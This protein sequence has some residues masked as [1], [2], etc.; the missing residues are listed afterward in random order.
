MSVHD[1]NMA[2]SGIGGLDAVFGQ[3]VTYTP[4]GE[5]GQECTARFTPT[6][7]M[8]VALEHGG[9]SDVTSGTLHVAKTAI[10]GTPV[11][12]ATVTIGSNTYDL[13]EDAI[14]LGSMWEFALELVSTDEIA[15]GD[16]HGGT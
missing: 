15:A 13:S 12:G 9:V 5:A 6:S 4:D 3:T 7:E 10:T 1:D 16:Y 11:R 14:D 2:A 8:P